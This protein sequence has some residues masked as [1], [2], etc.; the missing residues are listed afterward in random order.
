MKLLLRDLTNQPFPRDDLTRELISSVT[1]ATLN[2]WILEAGLSVDKKA[3]RY[4][5][6]EALA[7]LVINQTPQQQASKNN[8]V[9]MMIHE[10]VDDEEQAS[11]DKLVM[12][13][14]CHIS[15]KFK[16]MDDRDSI[17]EETVKV[18][19]MQR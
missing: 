5:K 7:K 12:S 4:A 2:K 19:E 13:T 8:E 14:I 1:I 10:T 15:K 18:S 3:K 16:S 9:E 11:K 17:V 6:E